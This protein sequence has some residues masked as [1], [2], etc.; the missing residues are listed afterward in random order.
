MFLIN[1]VLELSR[2]EEGTR[3]FE[4]QPLHIRQAAEYASRAVNLMAKEREIELSLSIEDDLPLVNLNQESI[5][6]VVINLLTNS[7]KYTPQ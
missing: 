6:R 2:V 4:M 3:D 5:E 1:D 7:I